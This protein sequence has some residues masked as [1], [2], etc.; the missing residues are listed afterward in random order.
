MSLSLD[1]IIEIIHRLGRK[2]LYHLSQT[3]TFYHNLIKF[4]K[5]IINTIHC[6]LRD[7]LKEYYEPFLKLMIIN[8]AFISGSFLI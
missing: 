5:V 3:S 2:E 4:D 8:N 6:R 1:N 7:I